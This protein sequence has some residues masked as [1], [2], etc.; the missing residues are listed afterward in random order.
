LKDSIIIFY[1]G[2]VAT[3]RVVSVWK[4]P[5]LYAASSAVLRLLNWFS[6]SNLHTHR[7]GISLSQV[8][9]RLHGAELVKWNSDER[10]KI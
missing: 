9:L 1:G 6:Y 5:Y 10:Y 7:T 4:Y 8:S 2:A 3:L